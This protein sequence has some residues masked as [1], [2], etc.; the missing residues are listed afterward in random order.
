[1]SAVGFADGFVPAIE[2]G[3]KAHTFRRRAFKEGETLKMFT[4]W[5]TPQC[6]QFGAAIATRSEPMQVFYSGSAYEVYP[7][8]RIVIRLDSRTLSKLESIA[9][10]KADGFESLEE[11]GQFMYDHYA[12]RGIVNIHGYLNH[13]K[14]FKKEIHE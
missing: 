8:A 12:E 6:K 4:G 9:L 1:M 2:S 3:L 10:A 5:R 13:W 7:Y 14:G 11:F